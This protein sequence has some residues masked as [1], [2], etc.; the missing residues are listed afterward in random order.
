MA[1]KGLSGANINNSCIKSKFFGFF[2]SKR[3]KKQQKVCELKE[4]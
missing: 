2:L 1:T 3:Q 4:N